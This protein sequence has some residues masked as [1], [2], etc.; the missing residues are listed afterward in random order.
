MT[1]QFK[2]GDVVQLQSGSDQMPM[3]ELIPEGKV[4]CL[5]W[6]KGDFWESIFAPDELK[7]AEAPSNPIDGPAKAI[8][9]GRKRAAMNRAQP[10]G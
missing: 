3:R 4:L 1:E 6:G 8:A 10:S 7:A 9:A 5:W 2:T